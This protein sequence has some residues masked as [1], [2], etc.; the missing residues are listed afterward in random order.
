[1]NANEITT[2]LNRRLGNYG[3]ELSAD[4]VEALA[5]EIPAF[6]NNEE[7]ATFFSSMAAALTMTAD[8]LRYA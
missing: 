1:M 3:F 6:P 7:L 5:N 8:E 2:D 4:L